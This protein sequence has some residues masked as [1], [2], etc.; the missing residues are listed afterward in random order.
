MMSKLN[1]SIINGIIILFYLSSC[2]IDKS[3]KYEFYFNNN[4]DYILHLSF[5]AN[6]GDR[7]WAYTIKNELIFPDE[8]FKI[9]E[10]PGGFLIEAGDYFTDSISHFEYINIKKTDILI[11]NNDSLID[12]KPRIFW[13]FYTKDNEWIGVY[14]IAVTNEFIDS[15]SMIK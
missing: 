6:Y 5:A 4:T 11:N 15:I 14:K 9:H 13:D 12:I 10:A 8:S 3:S 7:T 1:F 2:N